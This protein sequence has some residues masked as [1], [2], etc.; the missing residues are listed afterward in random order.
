MTKV[1]T[2]KIHFVNQKSAENYLYK[3]AQKLLVIEL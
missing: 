3:N 1:K 2:E